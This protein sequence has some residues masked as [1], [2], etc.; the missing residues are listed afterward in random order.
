VNFGSQLSSGVVVALMGYNA[1][2]WLCFG[3][4]RSTRQP[5]PQRRIEQLLG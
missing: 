5:K 2:V 4:L 3:Q 1:G